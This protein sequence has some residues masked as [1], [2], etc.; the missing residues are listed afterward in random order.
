M[1][2]FYTN[3]KVSNLN[4]VHPEPDYIDFELLN[5][6]SEYKQ[7]NVQGRAVRD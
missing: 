6:H 4:F 3:S 7:Q 5:S 2:L 1:Y